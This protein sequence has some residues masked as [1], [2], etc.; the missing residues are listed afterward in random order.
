MRRVRRFL[1][2]SRSERALLLQAIFSIIVVRLALPRLSLAKARQLLNR[3]I[4]RFHDNFAAN[5]IAW[6]IRAAARLIPGSTCLIQALAAQALLIRYGHSARLNIGVMKGEQPSF[7]A[8]AWVTC[9]DAVVVGG[10]EVE[11]YILLFRNVP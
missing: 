7:V 3:I 11:S 1:G 9:E 4:W 6:A 10:A 2:L 5:R 8:H